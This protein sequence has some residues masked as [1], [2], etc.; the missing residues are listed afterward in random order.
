[1]ADKLEKLTLM[2]SQHDKWDVGQPTQYRFQLNGADEKVA[3]I[4]EIAGMIAEELRRQGLAVG[5]DSY[6]EAYAAEVEMGIEDGTLQMA[7]L[8]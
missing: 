4:E 1:M 8:V 3:L 5:R 2:S 6:L 7:S